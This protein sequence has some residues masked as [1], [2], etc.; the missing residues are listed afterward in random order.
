MGAEPLLVVLIPVYGKAEALTPTLESIQRARLPPGTVTLVVDDGSEPALQIAPGRYPR[1]GLRVARLPRNSGIVAALN[2]GLGLVR[3]MG[4]TYVAR[5][6]AGDTIDPARLEKQLAY[7]EAHPEAGIVGSDVRFVDEQ[8]RLLFRFESP[9]TDEEARKRMHVNCSLIHPS[10]MLRLSALDGAYSHDY[11][12]A[13]DYELFLRILERSRA[14]SIP[15]PLTT[16]VVT[17]RGISLVRR[18][19]QLRSRLRLQWRYFDPARP[20]SYAGLALTLLFFVL[21]SR[22]LAALK[23]AAGATRY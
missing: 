13:E 18:R 12:A 15:E 11:P 17:A 5:L 19:A 10:V 16:S 6:D 7:L 9:R 2:F 1:L 21:P 3:E 22:L 4:A 14:A 20:E 8:G 23:G